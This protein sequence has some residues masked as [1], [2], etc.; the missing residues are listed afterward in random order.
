MITCSLDWPEKRDELKKKVRK[1]PRNRELVILLNNIDDL[2]KDLSRAE[3][4]AR[5]HKKDIGS[6]KELADVNEAIET[7]EQWLVF[8][9]FI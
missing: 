5:R 6:L 4:D 2:V 7:L 9:A 1:V 3:V 8:G